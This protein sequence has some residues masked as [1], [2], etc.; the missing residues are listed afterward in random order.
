M[1]V[2]ARAGYAPRL[3][4]Y[5]GSVF[6]PSRART[7]RARWAHS[8][9]APAVDSVALPARGGWGLRAGD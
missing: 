2:P 6:K 3:L 4:L 8:S 5:F 9:A 1:G 7:A